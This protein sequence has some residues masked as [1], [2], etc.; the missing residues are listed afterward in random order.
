MERVRLVTVWQFPSWVHAGSFF[1]C[2]FV[3]VLAP[4]HCVNFAPGVNAVGRA[5]DLRQLARPFEGVGWRAY[6]AGYVV[7]FG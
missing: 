3:I 7:V 5:P 1:A 2:S 6:W 4:L